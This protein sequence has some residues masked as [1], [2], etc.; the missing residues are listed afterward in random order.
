MSG[1][2]WDR[3]HEAWDR[4][5]DPLD[6]PA[7]R[8]ALEGADPADLEAF[9]RARAALGAAARPP[10]APAHGPRRGLLFATA[11]AA[12]LLIAL[13]IGEKGSG[14]FS[15][16]EKGPDPF[17]QVLRYRIEYSTK[18]LGRSETTVIENGRVFRSR[19]HA[20]ADARI[21]WSERRSE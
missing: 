19:T 14:P 8:A 12:A 9:A 13:G 7:L 10:A 5:A 1:A 2:L 6:D 3:L 20:V 11:A 16:A 21:E 15:A 4:R 17:P 18:G